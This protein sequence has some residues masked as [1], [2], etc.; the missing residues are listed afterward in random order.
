MG[1]IIN[2][3]EMFLRYEKR[4]STGFTSFQKCI[5]SVMEALTELNDQMKCSDVLNF[6][7]YKE[8]KNEPKP[9]PDMTSYEFMSQHIPALVTNKA[10]TINVFAFA[11]FFIK[12]STQ[13]DFLDK[14]KPYVFDT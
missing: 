13:K 3:V 14:I 8:P 7:P 4:N 2:S 10:T 9:L 1:S 6:T 5:N 12:E 11:D